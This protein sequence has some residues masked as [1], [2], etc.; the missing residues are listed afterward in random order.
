MLKFPTI[1]SQFRKQAFFSTPHARK[2]VDQEA[3]FKRISWK[4]GQYQALLAE[5][6][7]KCLSKEQNSTIDF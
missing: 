7:D 6:N 3:D 5:L 1:F 4:D 2:S